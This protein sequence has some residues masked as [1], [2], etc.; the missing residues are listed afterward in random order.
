[1]DMVARYG[2]A[3]GLSLLALFSLGLMLRMA[4]K[5][6]DGEAFALELGL[7]KEAIDAARKAREDLAHYGSLPSDKSRS[8]QG[9][10]G[11]S[12]GRGS[13]IVT[14]IPDAAGVEGLLVA[15][16]VGEEAAAVTKMIEQVSS[17]VAHDAEGIAAM[18]EK[19]VDQP[20]R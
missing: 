3:A 20:T 8:G 14:P 19:W 17:H 12:S 10:A 11:D 1:M 5:G 2:P 18:I 15:K 7:P 4:K 13:P 16:E 6:H 9:G